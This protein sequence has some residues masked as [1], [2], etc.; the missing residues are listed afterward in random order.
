M[1]SRQSSSDRARR[2]RQRLVAAF[3]GCTLLATACATPEDVPSEPE[4]ATAATAW[5]TKGWPVA[6]PTDQGLDGVALEQLSSELAA[7]D[8]GNVDAFLVIRGGQLVH[9]GR[10]EVDYVEA[11]RD[12]DQ[13]PHQYNYYHPDW[14]P[15][16]QG[17]DVHTMQSVTKSW[18]SALI[19]VAIERG[20]IEG[21]DVPGLSFF[22]DRTFDDP[23]GRKATMSLQDLLTM[24]A[25]FAWDESTVPYTDPRNDCAALEASEDWIQFVLDKPLSHDPGTHWVYNSGVSTLLSGILRQATGLHAHDY[26][27]Q[28]LFAP[29]G[30]DD[31]HWKTT[32]LGLADTEGGLYLKAED[33]AKLGLLYLNDGVWDGQRLLPEG[34]VAESIKPWVEDILPD[35]E[36]RD[37]GYSYQWWI[38]RDGREGEVSVFAGRGYG[39]QFLI[40]APELDLIVVFTGWNIFDEPPKT[41]ELFFERILPAIS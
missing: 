32:P 38:P 33:L 11:S 16:Y 25:G 8:H 22:S 18:T 3:L 21:V 20:E 41:F 7:G 10:Y 27:A 23:D 15:F 12:F 30:I 36:R 31:F 26:A 5:P 19:G 6:E 40:V 35:N 37:T 24:R 13:T 28:Y 17:R 34:W 2:K 4:A 39:G 29:L 9:E 1:D 14:H